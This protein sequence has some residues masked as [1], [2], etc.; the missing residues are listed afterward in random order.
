[1]FN[2]RN[3]EMFCRKY[4]IK[5]SRGCHFRGTVP[6]PNAVIFRNHNDDLIIRFNE[7][8]FRK[9]EIFFRFCEILFR[10]YEMSCRY[11]EILFRKYIGS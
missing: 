10:F 8:S 5:K 7:I 6:N 4:E 3:Y 2:F 9:Y 11:Y 1:M